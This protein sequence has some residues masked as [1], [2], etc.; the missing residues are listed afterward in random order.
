MH[1]LYTLTSYPPAVGGAQTYGHQ[2]A[3]AL[4]PD[5]RVAVASH[6][7]TNRT[8]WLLGTTLNHPPASFY[9]IDG[10][11]VHQLGLSAWRK[12]TLVPAVLGYYVLMGRALPMIA[13]AISQSLWPLAANADLIHNVRIGREGL[14]AASLQVARQRDI[15]FL[16]TPVHHPRWVGWP[17]QEYGRLYRQA[18]AL[19]ALTE[20]EK[21]ILVKIGVTAEKI[22]VTG[23]GPVLA[24]QSYPDGFRQRHG[25]QGPMVLFL[26]QHYG[27]K[28]YRQVLEAAPAV[29]R[30]HPDTHFVFMG[31]PVRNSEVIFASCSDRRIH[32]LGVA[33]LQEKTDALAA[34]SLLCVPSLQESFGGV[35]LEAW[36]FSKPVIGG[37]SPALQE[38]IREGVDGYLVEQKADP[39]S[40]RICYLLKYPAEALALGKAGYAKLQQRYQWPQLARQTLAI[41]QTLVS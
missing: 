41:Y 32:R 8:D 10:I 23:M 7:R 14:T 26:G 33:S 5:H 24:P 13:G 6:W 15:P 39:I 4:A 9:Q 20:A 31:P 22:H 3:Q 30:Q 21:A 34:C 29:W 12:L 17:Y 11:P 37:L 27:Y 19:I 25:I 36:S 18:D 1:L 38:V 16:L 40:D 2:L 35:Y 28:G